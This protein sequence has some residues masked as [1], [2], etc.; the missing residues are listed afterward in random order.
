M[1]NVAIVTATR[2]E[3]GLLHNLI[4]LV[5]GDYELKLQLFVTGAHLLKSQGNTLQQIEQQFT[6][7][8]KIP[9]LKEGQNTD[10]DIAL[11]TSNA[12]SGFA[13][14]FTKYKPDILV[15]LGDR[16]ELLGICSAALLTH[17]PIA[18]IHGGEITAGAM[19]DAIRHSVTKL[20]NLHFV[21]SEEYENRVLQMGEQKNSVFNVGAIGLDIVNTT[22]YLSKEQ[23]EEMLDIQ[24]QGKLVLVTYHPVSWGSTMGKIVLNKIFNAVKKIKNVT[25]I[26]TASNTDSSGGTLNKTIKKWAEQ[27]NNVHYIESLGSQKYLS[28]LKIADLVLGNSSSGIIEAP[29]FG[30][31]TVNIGE[32]Q[33]GRLRASSIIDCGETEVAIEKA[34]TKAFSNKFKQQASQVKSLYGKGDTPSKIIKEI[35]LFLGSDKNLVSKAFNDLSCSKV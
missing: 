24:L 28:M 23:L 26:W 11:A 9:I 18:H 31:P 22:N 19:D 33:S 1:K 10:L 2:A 21:A 16:Y 34:I 8:E 5:E 30:L 14:V 4:K 6:I 12:L 20:A 15:V 32:R 13:E 7:T 29:A 3:Y 25:V 35:K 27:Q 17:I